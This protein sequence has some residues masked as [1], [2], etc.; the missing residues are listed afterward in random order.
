MDFRPMKRKKHGGAMKAMYYGEAQRLAV[1]EEMTL[2]AISEKITVPLATL[3]RWSKQGKFK[4][5]RDDYRKSS[6]SAVRKAKMVLLD[7]IKRMDIARSRGKK[8]SSAD[9]DQMAKVAATIE[10]LDTIITP[11]RAFVIF[12]SRFAIWCKEMYPDDKDFL[13]RMSDAIQGFGG[14]VLE[15]DGHA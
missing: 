12:A 13:A 14:V 11:R 6:S 4:M 1:E 7:I 8:I 2:A 15:T 5:Q 3:R 10:R 9:V